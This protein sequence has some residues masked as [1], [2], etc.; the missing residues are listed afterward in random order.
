MKP[1]R[2]WIKRVLQDSAN[3]EIAMP[4]TRRDQQERAAA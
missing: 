4:W 1:Q 3:P 2:R